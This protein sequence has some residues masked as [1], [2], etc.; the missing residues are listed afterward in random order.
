MSLWVEVIF[1]PESAS[2]R[3][4][5]LQMR[6]IKVPV[7]VQDHRNDGRG[8]DTEKQQNHFWFL[9]EGSTEVINRQLILSPTHSR[10]GS[11]LLVSSLRDGP[12][13]PG[14]VGLQ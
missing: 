7:A 3:A 1:M 8:M 9:L 11:S 12:V 2:V 4:L 13:Y 10:K 5:F 6:L 14:A